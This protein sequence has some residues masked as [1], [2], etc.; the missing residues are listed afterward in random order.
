MSHCRI[1]ASMT[2]VLPPWVTPPLTFTL[3]RSHQHPHGVISPPPPQ[4]NLEY[5]SVLKLEFKMLFILL[6]SSI[7]TE[8]NS[9]KGF[10]PSNN[11]SKQNYNR[12][13]LKLSIFIFDYREI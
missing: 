1:T 8:F 7:V 12:I 11:N 4:N 5:R 3:C 10:S 2:T 6:F 13:V 9:L